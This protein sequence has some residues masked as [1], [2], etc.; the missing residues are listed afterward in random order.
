MYS[1]RAQ[2]LSSSDVECL[3][4]DPDGAPSPVDPNPVGG[5]AGL[6]VADAGEDTEGV[7][8]DGVDPDGGPNPTVLTTP[9]LMPLELPA[10]PDD[11]GSGG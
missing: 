2:P 5:G 9:L 3:L 10:P 8:P 4:E 1:S 11:V 6:E 7:G